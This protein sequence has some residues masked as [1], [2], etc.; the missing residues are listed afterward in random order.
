MPARTCA[1]GDGVTSG[2]L[3]KQGSDNQ[4]SWVRV[5]ERLDICQPSWLNRSKNPLYFQ[6]EAKLT[7][8]MWSS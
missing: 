8:D 7:W 5:T 2:V 4:E 3:G 6:P 1:P